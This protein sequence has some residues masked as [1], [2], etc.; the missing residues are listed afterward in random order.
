MIV[1]FLAIAIMASIIRTQISDAP[2]WL[3][4]CIAMSSAVSAKIS[5]WYSCSWKVHGRLGSFGS[6]V[7]LVNHFGM[8]L[9]SRAS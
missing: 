3:H 7:W 8:P 1:I 6:V 9:K 4:F 2:T 5:G